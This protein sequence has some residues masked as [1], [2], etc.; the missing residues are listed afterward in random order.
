[1][2]I[3][4]LAL[5]FVLCSCSQK[6]VKS[7]SLQII[8][9]HLHFNSKK[10]NSFNQ[11]TPILLEKFQ[12]NHVVGGVVH[13]TDEENFKVSVDRKGSIKWMTCVGLHENDKVEK[14]EKGIKEGRFQCIKVYLGYVPKW[15]TDPFYRGFYRLAE[16]YQLPVVFHTGD[17]HDK[18]AKVKFADPLQIDEVAVEYPK[19]KFVIAHMG[20]PWFNSA[21]EV[22]YKND[23]VYVDVS[24]LLLG[25][26]S[27]MSAE[28]LD[29]LVIKPVRWFYS[30]VENPKKF[31]FGSD[32]PLVEMD[33]YIDLM[34]KIVPE[35]DWPGFFY[36][37]A[38]EVFRF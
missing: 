34:K 21:A 23:N 20:N 26:I 32:W 25:D 16:R 11:P 33:P 38:K 30:Y 8:D 2:K 27:H 22:V 13:L 29:E 36:D 14:V 35:K 17:T 37:N 5:V 3:L 18:M 7:G 24:G 12:K 15:A 28:D 19:V 6:T 10:L 9:A 1:M 31:L 4:L